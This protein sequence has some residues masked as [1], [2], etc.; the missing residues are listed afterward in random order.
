MQPDKT[1]RLTND[2]EEVRW[3][4]ASMEARLQ[5]AALEIARLNNS[6]GIAGRCTRHPQDYCHYGIRLDIHRT[7]FEHRSDAEVKINQTEVLF[8]LPGRARWD[9]GVWHAKLHDDM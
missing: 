5:P 3:I 6:R 1:V 4:M 8:C 2:S 7:D 9:I